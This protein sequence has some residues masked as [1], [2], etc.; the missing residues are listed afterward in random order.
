MIGDYTYPLEHTL[1][2]LFV[3]GYEF[4]IGSEDVTGFQIIWDTG[5]LRFIPCEVGKIQTIKVYGGHFQV[6]TMDCDE[7]TDD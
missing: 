3:G 2:A 4:T 6:E 5:T 1:D 7:N